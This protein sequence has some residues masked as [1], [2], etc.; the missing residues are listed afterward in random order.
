MYAVEFQT[1]VK[2]DGS[3][4]IPPAYRSHLK[5]TIRVIILA[6]EPTTKPS[7]IRRLLEN[8]RRVENFTPFRRDEIY[9]RSL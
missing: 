3:I 5:G 6:E 1:T 9:N 8:P 2:D 4:D 7:I